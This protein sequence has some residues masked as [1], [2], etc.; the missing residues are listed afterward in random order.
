MGGNC[1]KTNS[2]SKSVANCYIHQ[3][4]WW[5][6]C[7]LDVLASPELTQV[8]VSTA[9]DPLLYF[10]RFNFQIRQSISQTLLF[11]VLLGYRNVC[12]IF[13]SSKGPDQILMFNNP[14]INSWKGIFVWKHSTVLS[15]NIFRKILRSKGDLQTDHLLTEGWQFKGN[16]T[17]GWWLRMARPI[18][19]AKWW[20]LKSI[21]YKQT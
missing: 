16:E 14:G 15:R 7:F 17:R 6:M 20:R 4:N 9:F 21:K 18:V 13:C 10:Q 3:I 11:K 8:I 19:V 2:W 5:Q 1:N 12:W